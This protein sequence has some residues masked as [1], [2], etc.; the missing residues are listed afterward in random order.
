MNGG[1]CRAASSVRNA[2]LSTIALQ[3]Q[4]WIGG[5]IMNQQKSIRMGLNG[6]APR[7]RHRQP[8]LRNPQ[9]PKLAQ[10]EGNEKRCT[11]VGQ[12]QREVG[13]EKT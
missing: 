3:E 1:C 9:A 2:S 7:G 5:S 10:S 13:T 4:K 6:S 12:C 8:G 11:C